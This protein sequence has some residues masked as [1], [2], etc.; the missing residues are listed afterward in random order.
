MDQVRTLVTARGGS[1]DDAK[2]RLRV[3]LIHDQVA[4]TP[5]QMDQMREEILAVVRRYVDVDEP[6]VEFRLERGDR[7]IAL[8]SNMPVRRAERG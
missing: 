4:L 6:G 3:V 1:K 7:E 8:V 5:G 2:Q